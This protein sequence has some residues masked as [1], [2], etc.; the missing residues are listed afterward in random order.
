MFIDFLNTWWSVI[1]VIWVYMSL[2][3]GISRLLKRNDVADVAW[4]LGFIVAS[5]VPVFAHGFV[6]NRA[7][8]V[9]ALVVIWGGRLAY[10]IFRRNMN[11]PEDGRYV[12][13]RNAWGKHFAIRSYGQIFM[14]QGLLL[15]LIATPVLLVNTYPGVGL[16]LFDMIGFLVWAFGFYFE[17]QGDRQLR[18]FIKNPENKG[19]I[20][21]TGLWKYTRHPNYF[22]EVTQWWGIWIIALSV[23]YS[24]VGLVGPIAITVLILKVSGI[25]L[26]EK[27]MA[28]N[29]LFDEYRKTTSVFFPRKPK[30]VKA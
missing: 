6:S 19:K 14:L 16:T 20:L 22:G 15:I 29:P 9:T 12:A 11:K 25:P 4:G 27:K 23:P 28:E 24:L 2:W 8:F 1:L 17:S 10:H 7:V 3:F 21:N 13:W 26:L 30:S 18:A 5:L